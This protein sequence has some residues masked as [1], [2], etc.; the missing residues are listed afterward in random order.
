MSLQKIKIVAA[1]GALVLLAAT[2]PLAR[3]WLQERRACRNTALAGCI[4]PPSSSVRLTE[5]AVPTTPFGTV[6][7]V[8]FAALHCAEATPTDVRDNKTAII[9]VRILSIL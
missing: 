9:R 8:M 2:R 7:G 3:A 6:V 5:Y 4:E 1:I